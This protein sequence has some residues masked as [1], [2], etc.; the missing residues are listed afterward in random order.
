MFCYIDLDLDDSR[1]AYAR[2]CEFV[3]KCSIKYGLSSN[4]LDELG[5]REKISIPDLVSNDY[6]YAPKGR[7]QVKPQ[8]SCRLVFELFLDS[9]PLACENFRALCTGSKGVSK[10]SGVPLHYK[11]SIIHRYVSNFVLQGGDITHGNGVGGESIWGKKFKDDPKGLKLKHNKRGILSMGNGGKNSNTSQFFVTLCN[12]LKA[13]DGKHT[14]FGQLIHGFE[15]LD[16]IEQLKSSHTAVESAA[17]TAETQTKLGNAD[18]AEAP[19]YPIVV[20]S[21]GDWTPD[22]PV[23]GYWAADDTFRAFPSSDSVVGNDQGIDDGSAP[24]GTAIAD[25]ATAST[26]TVFA[27]VTRAGAE[28]PSRPKNGRKMK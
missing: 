16:L 10:Q 8:P 3:N 15:T 26:T 28:V 4:V 24:D 2:A 13:C 27:A 12:E 17:A 1:A 7:V 9:S 23:S 11:N 22:M 19:P 6:N 25:T 14:V 20:T 21:C 5:G 18:S